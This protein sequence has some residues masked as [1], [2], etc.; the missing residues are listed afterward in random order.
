MFPLVRITVGIACYV[1]F[2]LDPPAYGGGRDCGSHVYLDT[3]T[4]FVNMRSEAELPS[5]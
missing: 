3:V 1:E 2:N 5:V 4:S